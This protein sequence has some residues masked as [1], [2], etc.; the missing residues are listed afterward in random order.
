MNTEELMEMILHYGD[1]RA[2]SELWLTHSLSATDKQGKRE[3]KA[4]AKRCKR[5]SIK[6]LAQIETE[7]KKLEGAK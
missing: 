2:S 6:L 7:L 3:L 4:S 5:K 1:L